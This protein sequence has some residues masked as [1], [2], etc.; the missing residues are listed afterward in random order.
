MMSN[1]LPTLSDYDND[2]QYWN[3]IGNHCVLFIFVLSC[4][5]FL[6]AAT[7]KRVWI[8]V[9]VKWTLT[10]F[11]CRCCCDFKPNLQQYI[12]SEH[13]CLERRQMKLILVAVSFE[14]ASRHFSSCH[15]VMVCVELCP[16]Y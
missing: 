12:L 7:K 6:H 14:N 2:G 8:H 13:E 3:L 4:E 1:D 5:L 16:F 9:K 10:K 11:S 15:M